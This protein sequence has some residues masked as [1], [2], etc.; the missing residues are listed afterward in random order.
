MKCFKDGWMMFTEYCRS[1]NIPL[2]GNQIRMLGKESDEVKVDTTPTGTRPTWA[3]DAN[4]LD[5]LWDKQKQ[6]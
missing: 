2:N 1:R 3:V 4:A 5:K 6:V